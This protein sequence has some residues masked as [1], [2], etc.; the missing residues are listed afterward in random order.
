MI[1]VKKNKA[2]VL[3]ALYNGSKPLGLGFIREKTEG[4]EKMGMK[5]AEALL[6]NSTYFDYLKGRVMKVDLSGD[7]FDPWFYDR[8]NGAGSAARAISCLD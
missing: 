5:E 2:E 8:A 1:L 6:K 4:G 7:E 3:A